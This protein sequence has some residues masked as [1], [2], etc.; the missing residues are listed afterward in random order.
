[1]TGGNRPAPSRPASI[2]A[3]RH[4]RRNG[5]P[6]RVRA[7]KT[8]AAHG[9]TAAASPAPCPI[10]THATNG[11]A[12][13]ASGKQKQFWAKVN[14][15]RYGAT[16]VL[17][18]VLVPGKDAQTGS[19]PLS[20]VSPA[21]PAQKKNKMESSIRLPSPQT[22]VGRH[23]RRKIAAFVFCRGPG[24]LINGAPVAL[25]FLAQRALGGP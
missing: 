23:S 11:P 21:T 13:A 14:P 25:R 24:M 20:G 3:R 1:M 7:H 16:R 6:T 8:A 4:Q 10:S 18:L 9:K 22:L 2:R 12:Q 15:I 5:G 19:P 17:T